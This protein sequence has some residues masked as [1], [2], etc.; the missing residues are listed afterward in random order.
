MKKCEGIYI[1]VFI[2]NNMFIIYP[3]FGWPDD[4][5]PLS[6]ISLSL[7]AF[8]AHRKLNVSTHI[9]FAIPKWI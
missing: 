4:L 7:P 9:A 2:F 8:L 3:F 6:F 5:S 1:C